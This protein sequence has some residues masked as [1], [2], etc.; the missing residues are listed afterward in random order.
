[1][2]K[3]IILVYLLICKL[4]LGYINIYPTFFY[5]RLEDNKIFKTII[6]TNTTEKTIRYRLYTEEDEYK[7]IKVEIYPKS[8]T[9]KPLEKKEVKI[10]MTAQE[11]IVGEFSKKLVVKEIELP[12]EKKKILTM[13]KLKLSG[14]GGDIEPKL[15]IKELGGN[16]FSIKNVGKRVGIYDIYNLE[17]E[18]IDAIILKKDEVK[19][20]KIDSETLIFEEKF[21]GKEMVKRGISNET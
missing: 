11:Q 4:A 14:F 5:E 19:E 3:R 9:L 10:L 17:E 6:L 7:N 12:K 13:F 1:M 20:L 21:K 2:L 18:F 8:V 15:E 16:R